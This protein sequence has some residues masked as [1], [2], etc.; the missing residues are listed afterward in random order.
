MSVQ[1]AFTHKTKGAFEGAKGAIRR[2]STN[3]SPTW[4]R[5]ITEQWL[6]LWSQTGSFSFICV[7]ICNINTLP[8][9]QPVPY[10]RHSPEMV[11]PME[12]QNYKEL[13]FRWTLSMKTKKKGQLKTRGPDNY[14]R[15][16][17][18]MFYGQL[19]IRLHCRKMSQIEIKW[20][21]ATPGPFIVAQAAD[22]VLCR[23]KMIRFSNLDLFTRSRQATNNRKLP[24]PIIRC[25][26]TFKDEVRL[27]KAMGP[28]NLTFC[29]VKWC[30][31]DEDT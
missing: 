2:F 15:L 22:L 12:N 20:E 19:L 4:T 30:P 9:T 16:S 1:C 3:G 25:L 24:M 21:R 10:I 11:N 14:K 31:F 26:S 13:P 5:L 7:Y 29:C 8:G 18:P 28:G 6:L 23:L 27:Q 17:R